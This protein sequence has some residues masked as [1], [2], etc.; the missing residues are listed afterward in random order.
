MHVD[1]RDPDRVRLHFSAPAE[2]PT[3]RGFASILAA[4]LDARGDYRS[5]L[6]LA[7]HSAVESPQNA[8]VHELTSL[9][10]FA[11]GEYRGAATEAHA[12]LALGAPSD[13]SHLYA[14]YNDSDRYTEQLR[15]LEKSVADAPNSAPGHFLLGYQYLMTGAK[16][17]AKQHFAQAA[18]LT[19]NDKLAQHILKQLESS[20]EV[21]PPKLPKQPDEAKGKSLYAPW[22][23]LSQLHQPISAFG[24]ANQEHHALGRQG[25]LCRL[26]EFTRGTDRLLIDLHDEHAAADTGPGSRSIRLDFLDER[27]P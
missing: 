7:G 5:A 27:L 4:G 14:Y 21:T 17:E 23:R 25:V 10:L 2:A 6:R 22:L 18:K 20:G 1:A 16:D 8:K 15:K 24:R 11:S 19:P 26:I 3:T 12:A 13:W 9:A